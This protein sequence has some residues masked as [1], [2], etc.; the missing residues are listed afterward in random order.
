MNNKSSELEVTV[1]WHRFDD[2]DYADNALLIV[3]SK[4]RTIPVLKRFEE[5]AGTVEMYPPWF[6]TKNQNLGAGLPIQPVVVG[7]NV[8]ESVD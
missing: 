4:E 7:G 6:K 5:L 8:V 2:L 3:D 1:G